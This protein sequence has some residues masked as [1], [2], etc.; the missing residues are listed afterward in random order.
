MKKYLW[1]MT[2]LV[3]AAVGLSFGGGGGKPSV[4]TF[5]DERDGKVY[6]TVKIGAQVW[7]AE[8]LNYDAAGGKCYA[9][10]KGNCAKY[11]RL[12]NW[13]TAMK[14]CPAGWHLPTDREW[15]TLVDYAGGREKAGTKLK[16]STGWRSD[17]CT[18]AATDNYGF[19]A[20]PGGYGY[21]TDSYLCCF[22]DVD[23]Y[24]YWWSA[25]AYNADFAR[26]RLM[27]DDGERVRRNVYGKVILFSVRCV[28]N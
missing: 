16:S 15:T 27:Y 25:T 23:N 2:A 20:L 13:D 21:D 11:G 18:P 28:Q 6:K 8:N 7:M 12:Y 9:N 17:E 10:N 1:A 22:Y 3:L 14:A 19:S 4:S 26:Y 24:G 5:T